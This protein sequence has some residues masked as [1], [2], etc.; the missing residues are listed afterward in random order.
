MRPIR[1]LA[2][3]LLV[4]MFAPLAAPY[5][6]TRID[7]VGFGI[8]R[9]PSLLHP[10]GTDNLA[11]DVLSRVLT[12]SQTSLEVALSAV[13]VA[14]VVGTAYGALA[15]LSGGWGD[16]LLMR[17][18]DFALAIPR[19]L[20]L[21]AV[22]AFLPDLPLPALALLL[23]LTGARLTRGDLQGL[24]QR[25]FVLASDAIGVPRARLVVRHLLPHLLPTLTVIGTLAIG[26][27]IA[28]EA[29]LGFLGLGLNAALRPSLGTILHDAGSD[30]NHWWLLV[31]PGLTIVLIMLACNAL[32]DALRERFAPRQFHA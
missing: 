31:F 28:L 7:E 26:S 14:L 4:I 2:W 24:L 23:G 1:L 9:A 22:A 30:M 15:A 18:V 10:F 21:L 3:L 20:V 17:L 25:D 13:A 19:V 5:D 29:G 27:T 6:P 11:R 32:G 12:G 8:L 16:A